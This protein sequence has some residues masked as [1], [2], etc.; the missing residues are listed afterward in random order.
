M[1]KQVI[2]LNGPSS[3]GKSSLA[4]LLQGLIW[5]KRRERYEIISIDD[6]LTMTA[7]EPICEE[8]VYEISQNLC[9]AASAAL[10]TAD[11]VIMDHVITS[12][13]IFDQLSDALHGYRVWMIRVSCPLEV[14]REREAARGNRC[15]GSAEASAAYLF[16]KD[17]YDLTVDT[18]GMTAADNAGW[19]YGHCFHKAV[20]Y[21]HGRGGSASESEHY[22]ALFPECEVMGLDYQTFTPWETGAE[23]RAAV[24][25]LKAENKRV[26]LIANS[27]GAYF[28]MNAGIDAMIE[29]AWFISPIVDMEKL[30]TDMMRWAN[31]TET[32]LEARGTIH[33]AFGED[34]SW[35]YLCHVRSH[36][37]CWTV[38]TRILY[39]SHDNLTSHETIRDFAKKHHAALTIMEGGEHWFHTEEQMRFLDDWIMKENHS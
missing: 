30:I 27:I 13:R 14:L 36:P 1:E 23:I 17:G 2:L 32:E 6:F 28:C 24:E 15:P 31:V 4:Q 38:P 10:E 29:K 33:T 20:L 37:T 25:A 22:K 35:N 7:Q 11:G 26:I 39:G 5:T 19:I 8:D 12:K 21:I 16:P 18:Y 3:S 34:L 9:E